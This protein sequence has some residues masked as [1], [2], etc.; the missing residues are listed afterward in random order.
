MKKLSMIL[1][2][3]LL[4]LGLAQCNKPEP[5]KVF[6]S[7][8]A[9]D[10]AKTNIDDM[11]RVTFNNG[12]KLHVYGSTTGYLGVLTTSDAN[13]TALP[14]FS[15]EIN[16]WTNGEDL[17]FFYLGGNT[18]ADDGT[19]AINFAD[20]SYEGTQSKANDLANIAERFH[21]S[22]FVQTNVAAAAPDA[23]V[24]FQGTLRNMMAIGL[25]NTS[26]FTDAATSHVKM[27]AA[28]P[29]SPDSD[30]SGLKNRIR[31]SETGE[32]TYD[33]CGIGNYEKQSGWIVTG[34]KSSARFVALLP[35]DG[36]VGLMFTSQGYK[37]SAAITRT[38][39]ANDYI[40][41][42]GNAAIAV[43]AEAVS[44][45]YVDLDVASDHLF[46]VARTKFVRFTKG[47]LVYDQGR[48]KMFSEQYGTLNPEH[49]D[50]TE[51]T[52]V[53]GTFSHFGWG[54]SGYPS[55]NDNLTMPHTYS[56]LGT[57]YYG[58]TTTALW[59][60]TPTT[61]TWTPVSFPQDYLSNEFDWGG[62]QFGMNT[63]TKWRTLTSEEWQWLLG[64]VEG[65][66]PTDDPDPNPSY[67]QNCRNVEKRFM[68][69]QIL[70]GIVDVWGTPTPVT[71]NGLII[72]PDDFNETLSGSYTFND[73]DS[74]F[75]EATAD[76]ATME[77]AGC[78]FLPAQGSRSLGALVNY[79]FSPG[80]VSS[81]NATGYY[82]TATANTYEYGKA[83]NLVFQNQVMGYDS[84][85][86]GLGCSVRLVKDVVLPQ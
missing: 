31:I 59:I 76:W 71:I 41:G 21:V 9:V 56:L 7:F 45:D 50:V 36:S 2:A 70:A 20:Q 12:D 39:A 5:E 28:T 69:A 17:R 4:V 64:P 42:V 72:F 54:T 27:Y 85:D 53:D 14:L 74:D 86:R 35:T 83:N 57:N 29:E 78:V 18:P 26:A 46:N 55:S 84:H 25:F 48:F 79:Q 62:Y 67:V 33:A 16:T 49:G 15:G 63:G 38:I 3:C 10:G 34:P 65:A 8:Q 24:S 37:S 80:T 66:H 30:W 75:E 19:I 44:S 6:V 68:K 51:N 13:G 11:G 32:L 43:T 61:G 23:T 73:Y 81:V 58:P 60:Y 22:R 40:R 77:S 1:T 47:N 52:V 82:W